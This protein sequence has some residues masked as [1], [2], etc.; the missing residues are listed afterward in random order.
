MTASLKNI[1]K[2]I[3]R[4]NDGFLYI[5]SRPKQWG[6]DELDIYPRADKYELCSKILNTQV[7]LRILSLSGFES[8]VSMLKS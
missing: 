5:F 6:N 8:P 7:R 1:F 4:I 3:L 2:N